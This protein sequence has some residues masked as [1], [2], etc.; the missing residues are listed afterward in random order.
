MHKGMSAEYIS[1]KMPVK[2]IKIQ[3]VHFFE[4][5]YSNHSTPLYCNFSTVKWKLKKL[6]IC[7]WR[8]MGTNGK[9]WSY[10]H[11]KYCIP[12]G[13][14]A[15]W[16]LVHNMMLVPASRSIA[17]F[18]VIL[19]LTQVQLKRCL[20]SI[21]QRSNNQIVQVFDSRNWIWLVKN[22]FS[23][24]IDNTHDTHNTCT[25]SVISWTSHKQ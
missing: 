14:C 10:T 7:I 25:A 19:E 6:Q 21:S 16:R 12:L 2:F 23:L 11:D 18:G 5:I 24:N 17:S 3:L 1:G 20:T 9:N 15:H 22:N 4:S 13:H 8:H